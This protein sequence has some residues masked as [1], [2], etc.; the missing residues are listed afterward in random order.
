MITISKL[1]EVRFLQMLHHGFASATQ[2]LLCKSN[3]SKLKNMKN[4]PKNLPYLLVFDS[5]TSEVTTPINN[6]KTCAFKDC[7]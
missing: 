1:G 5:V 2:F 7:S 4:E 3:W 6:N